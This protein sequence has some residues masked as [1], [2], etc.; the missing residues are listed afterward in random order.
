MK[1]TNSAP[2]SGLPSG[3]VRSNSPTKLLFLI[4]S[5][6]F[7]AGLALFL[8][9]RFSGTHDQPHRVVSRAQEGVLRLKGSTS[10]VRSR[11][12]LAPVLSGQQTGSLTITR[13]VQA[14]SNVKTGAP[15][16]EFDR[17]SQLREFLDKQAEYNKIAGQLAEQVA[18]ESAAKAKDETELHQAES[19][20]KNAEL[21]MKK[22]EL[23]SRIDN[24]KAQ[25]NLEQSKAALAQLKETFELKRKAAHAAIRILEIQRSRTAGIMEN[26]QK[27]ADAMLIRSPL[28]GVVV[29]ETI[30]KNGK[31]GE[32]QEGDQVRP[33]MVLMQVVD[34]SA[35]QV[36]VLI[37]QQDVLH[38]RLGQSAKV[39]L[40]AY[41]DLVFPARLE[42]IAPIGRSG[43]FS[44]K[45]RTFPALFSIQATDPR[46]MPDLSAAVDVEVQETPLA[47]DLRK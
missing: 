20:L 3:A 12:I 35:M 8:I 21:E 5:G 33:G 9:A 34:P 45:L 36:G 18:K 4:G 7:L 29:F 43:D 32:P 24:E 10:A 22:V 23:M 11:A 44:V 46:L 1:T 16:L 14:G 30:W 41:P 19:D 13:L 15:L 42:Q 28:D 2:E 27:N 25:Q 17:Q 39:Q 47:G 37:N 6:I 38:L 40:D 31:M 26:A